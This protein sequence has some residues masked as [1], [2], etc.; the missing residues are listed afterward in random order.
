MVCDILHLY[1]CLMLEE[2][3]FNIKMCAY[4]ITLKHILFNC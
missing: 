2:L 3:K 1:L 4:K